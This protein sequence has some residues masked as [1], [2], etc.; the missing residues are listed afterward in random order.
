MKKKS[1]I[2]FTVKKDDFFFTQL[3]GWEGVLLFCFG[4]CFFL[5]FCFYHVYS[6]RSVEGV[7][8][9]GGTRKEQMRVLDGPLRGLA[10]MGKAGVEYGQ[11]GFCLEA[12][13]PSPRAHVPSSCHPPV[14]Q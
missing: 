1:Q 4:F 10:S 6:A 11:G 8:G 13:L 2:L 14:P 9:K 7:S 5:C 3:G 12:G